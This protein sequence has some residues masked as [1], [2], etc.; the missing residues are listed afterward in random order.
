MA[1]VQKVAGKKKRSFKKKTYVKKGSQ[2]AKKVARLSKMVKET[3]RA[4]EWKRQCFFISSAN[5][6]PTG[7]NPDVHLYETDHVLS[8][9]GL[10][11]CPTDWLS[12]AV[13]VD[14]L[15]ITTSAN[16]GYTFGDAMIGQKALIKYL[17]IGVTLKSYNSF[18][19]TADQNFPLLPVRIVVIRAKGGGAFAPSAPF[20]GSGVPLDQREG[21]WS[22]PISFATAM[23]GKQICG[24]AGG[25]AQTPRSV[26]TCPLDKDMGGKSKQFHVLLDEIID[27]KVTISGGQYSTN[28][29]YSTILK[30][31][32]DMPVAFEVRPT[33]NQLF[34]N[35]IN[36]SNAV[37]DDGCIQIIAWND[38]DVGSAVPSG[39][40]N[41]TIS[42]NGFF[43][44][45]DA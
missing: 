33:S 41:Q 44:Y 40:N 28:G 24:F 38:Y 45:T 14:P 13:G 20:S 31:N 4:I 7:E 6:I 9:Q 42:I 43:S 16:Q 37:Y 30:L 32:L 25:Q 8:N 22:T 29:M 10:C 18:D 19:A 39:F 23:F 26:V 35:Y 36:G 12:S 3:S 27:P 1:D 5:Y 21:S 15:G 11:L 17:Q 2:L 34:P